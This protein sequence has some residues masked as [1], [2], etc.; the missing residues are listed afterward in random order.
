MLGTF[1]G[2]M[3][4]DLVRQGTGAPPADPLTTALIGSGASLLLTRGRR[5]AGVILLVAGGLLLWREAA[6]SQRAHTIRRVE[7]RRPAGDARPAS[8]RAG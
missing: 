8:A 1:A 3:M 4:A 6:A 7:P 5:P 2:S